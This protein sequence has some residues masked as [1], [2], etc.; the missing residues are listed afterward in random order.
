MTNKPQAVSCLVV[1]IS[2]AVICGDSTAQQYVQSKTY[3]LML[4]SML[5][6]DVAEIGVKQA[7]ALQNTLFLDAREKPEYYVSHIKNAQW[8][9]YTDFSLSR[10][11][12]ISKTTPIV[13]YCSV[14]YRSEKVTQQLQKAGFTNVS[15]LYG[16]IFE[17]VN[18]EQPLV[19]PKNKPT[20]KIHAYNRTWGVWLNK[21]EKVYGEMDE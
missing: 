6:H 7:A 21:G 8:V 15:N 5:A 18:Q 1:V 4:K 20:T 17:W 10:V 12:N 11:K 3:S 9:G 2:L 14:G 16:G 19:T 13:V